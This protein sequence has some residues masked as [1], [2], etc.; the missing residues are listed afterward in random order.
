MQGLHP[1]PWD[2]LKTSVAVSEFI[3]DGAWVPLV[4][5]V[6]ACEDTCR[7]GCFS[8]PQLAEVIEKLLGHSYLTLQDADLVAHALEMFHKEPDVDFVFHLELASAMKAGH[9]PVGTGHP[10]GLEGT[11]WIRRYSKG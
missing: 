9:L 7:L 4:S 10:Q 3:C 8:P 1:Q 6:R 5:L 2:L 11:Q